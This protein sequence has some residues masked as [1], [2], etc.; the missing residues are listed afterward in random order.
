MV[1]GAK[2]HFQQYF[3]YIVAVKCYWW[4]KLEYPEKKQPICRKSLTKFIT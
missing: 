4:R 1:G 3:S 2:C